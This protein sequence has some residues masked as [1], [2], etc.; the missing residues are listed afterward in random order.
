MEGLFATLGASLLGPTAAAAGTSAS[1]AATG[2]AVAGTVISG[3]GAFMQI[4]QQRAMLAEQIRIEKENELRQAAAGREEA[5]EADLEAAF[6]LSQE[7][8]QFG[9]S[10]FSL[11][12]TSY[13]RRAARNR[14][15]ARINRERIVE[16]A[17]LQAES[18]R[19]RQRGLQMER[20][21][22]GRQAAFSLL[23]TGLNFGSD[24]ITGSTL[25][26]SNRAR[27]LN[28]QASGV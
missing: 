19:N 14:I 17:D 28:T 6:A 27:R 16:D 8:A 15:N 13:E 3:V 23:E 18:A 24:L 22:L 10:G 4:Q 12:S 7:R 1:L 21:G 11:T 5:R 25:I 9:S 26:E 2:A 20:A